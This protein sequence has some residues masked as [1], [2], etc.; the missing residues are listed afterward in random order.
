[1]TDPVP[2]GR[3]HW[4]IPDVE[5]VSRLIETIGAPPI[6]VPPVLPIPDR[7]R[8]AGREALVEA[9]V[10][11]NRPLVVIHAGSING[12]AKRWPVSHWSRFVDQL[13]ARSGAQI[14]SIGSAADASLAEEVRAGAAAPVISVAGKTD[15]ES[16]IGLI[17]HADLVASGDSGPLH[18]AAAAERPLLAVYGPTDPRIHGPF[19]PIAPVRLLRSDIVCSPCYS[20]AA[21]AECPL[22]DPVCMRL[23]SVESMVERALELLQPAAKTSF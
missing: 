14:V 1:L 2:G 17:A 9:G 21:T 23:V 7:V 20:M 11:L 4:R 3:F 5:Y 16:L 12:S 22:G 8:A 6:D 19:R 10:D 18:L 15:I 13:H